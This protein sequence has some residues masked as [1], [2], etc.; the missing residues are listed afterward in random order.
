MDP[1]DLDLVPTEEI[2]KVLK[3]RH[4]GGMVFIGKMDRSQDLGGNDI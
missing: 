4:P 1:N 3:A 2:L